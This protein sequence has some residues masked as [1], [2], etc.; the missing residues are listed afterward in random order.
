MRLR[1][2]RHEVGFTQ[3]RVALDIH[4]SSGF[5]ALIESGA[6]LPSLGVLVSLAESLGC[7]VIDLLAIDPTDPRVVLLD[8]IRLRDWGRAERVLAE[9]RQTTEAATVR[10][11]RS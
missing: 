7:H 6:R 3:E 5:V 9:L 2:L 4:L 1:Q 10:P 8:A 11:T